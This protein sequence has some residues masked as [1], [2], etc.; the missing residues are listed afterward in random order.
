VNTVQQGYLQA[1]VQ[2]RYSQLP[3]EKLWLH[4]SALKK[5]NSFLEELRG[6]VLAE[7]VAGLSEN[8]PIEEIEAHIQQHLVSAIL[9]ISD[10]FAQRWKPAIQWLTT[11]FELSNLQ[12]R[13]II[14]NSDVWYGHTDFV[15]LLD[16]HKTNTGQLL[17]NWK[18][19]WY[20]LMPALSQSEQAAIDALIEIIEQHRLVFRSTAVEDAWQARQS[21]QHQLRY[22]F[23]RHVMKSAAA[24]TYLCL[25]AL[26]LERMQSELI[27]RALCP[28]DSAHDTNDNKAEHNVTGAAV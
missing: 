21:L 15:D 26:A 23:R 28:D 11:L 10:W 18:V 2:V 1:R 9:E 16:A 19:K 14:L 3:D 25:F 22:H 8:S 20:S 5:F 4:L 13:D 17:D 27:A 12:H 24:M 6:T 7:Y